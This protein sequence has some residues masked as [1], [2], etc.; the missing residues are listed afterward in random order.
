MEYVYFAIFSIE[1]IIFSIMITILYL[2]F[3]RIFK[4]TGLDKEKN[5]KWTGRLETIKQ[6]LAD[7]LNPNRN[8][9]GESN[10]DLQ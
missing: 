5:E 1:I 2:L 7:Y 4:K 6:R 10:L 9:S 8:L 3:Q